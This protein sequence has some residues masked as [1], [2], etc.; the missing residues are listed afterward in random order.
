MPARRSCHPPPYRRRLDIVGARTGRR[1]EGSRAQLDVSRAARRPTGRRETYFTRHVVVG[2]F[3][4]FVAV[5]AVSLL[6]LAS[7]C[8]VQSTPPGS[9]SGVF[10]ANG[11][12]PSRLLPGTVVFTSSTGNRRS[13]EIGTDG[14]I[15]VHL[16]PGTWTATGQSP[17]VHSDSRE[18]PCRS[19]TPVVVHSGRT[20]HA[21]VVCD[22]F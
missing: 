18:M 13:V 5:S 19:L 8:V 3:Q 12:T 21:N 20:T 2:M 16:A 10:E 11:V 1:R 15:S 7:G 6:A 4:R 17:L 9:V 14:S 22:L